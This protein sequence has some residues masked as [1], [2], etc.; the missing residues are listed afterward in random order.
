M[1]SISW[2]RL[3]GIG[4]M[5]GRIGNFINGEL[6]GKPTDL[7]WGFGVPNAE[8]HLIARHP[9]QLYEATLEGLVLFLVLWWFT[10]KPRPRLAPLG[11][12][13]HPL[14][15]RPLRRGMG[16]SARRQH[17]I[18]RRRLVDHGH[19]VDDTD[20]SRRR[21]H[22]DLCLPARH[23]ERQF[24]RRQKHSRLPSAAISG[25][26]AP[27][28]PKRDPQGRPHRHGHV[29]RI[30]PS[31]ALRPARGISARNHQAVAFALHHL[32]ASVVSP[33]RHQHP[34]PAR[35]QSDHLG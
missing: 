24:E 18:P 11:S 29:E 16:A 20:D 4:L 22:D 3:P 27:H 26:S 25:F 13:P 8:G 7:P 31:N 17:R 2:L 6:W 35:A 10:S 23:P 21:H 33:R 15:M 12:I 19:A 5:A 28:T 9:S 1:C 14:R 34:I 30:W 32:R